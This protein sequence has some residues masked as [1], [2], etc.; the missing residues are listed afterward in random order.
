MVEMA[1]QHFLTFNPFR[2]MNHVG[3]ETVCMNK[4]WKQICDTMWQVRRSVFDLMQKD[5]LKAVLS[6]PDAQ[7]NMHFQWNTFIDFIQNCFVSFAWIWFRK[8]GADKVQ[9]SVPVKKINAPRFTLENDTPDPWN[10][11]EFYGVAIRKLVMSSGTTSWSIWRS[12]DMRSAPEHTPDYW[13]FELFYDVLWW[14]CMLFYDDVSW[15]FNEIGE[16]L[17]MTFV[18]L[19][20]L[21]FQSSFPKVVANVASCEDIK[22][23][24][25]L[26]WDFLEVRYPLPKP[27]HFIGYQKRNKSAPTRHCRQREYGGMTWR[28][29]ATRSLALV[30]VHGEMWRQDGQLYIY[31]ISGN[32]F[33]QFFTLLCLHV[34][35]LVLLSFNLNFAMCFFA[36][37]DNWFTLVAVCK[38]FP[39]DSGRNFHGI[40][41]WAADRMRK[42]L[43]IAKI[44]EWPCWRDGVW[45]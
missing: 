4:Q 43:S 28:V 6:G 16:L 23:A 7:C 1:E 33:E 24:Q 5:Q 17:I 42:Q 30:K 41:L 26:L 31:N 36:V 35:L 27:G 40:T 38:K 34:E 15:W 8:T 11:I 10:C 2:C 32:I 25:S 29:G 19:R 45:T 9:T 21:S 22:K 12:M 14:R 44:V 39:S 13:C 37:F 18:T 3:T 20:H